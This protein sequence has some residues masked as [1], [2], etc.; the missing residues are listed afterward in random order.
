MCF[1]Y[2]YYFQLTR[3]L[4]SS[5]KVA[6]QMKSKLHESM[7]DLDLD[8]VEELSPNPQHRTLKQDIPLHQDLPKERFKQ[9][10]A[11][12]LLKEVQYVGEEQDRGESRVAGKVDAST[13]KMFE[14]RAEELESLR[15]IVQ[16]LK[17]FTKRYR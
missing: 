2:F 8:D 14:G 17:N 6:D 11:P 10:E 12:T 13:Y 3:T 15:R 16:V 5:S 9:K 7:A 1:Y 4:I